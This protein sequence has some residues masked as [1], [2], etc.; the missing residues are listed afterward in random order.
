MNAI[1]IVMYNINW[2]NNA[3]ISFL[4]KSTLSITKEV[5]FMAALNIVF[6][7]EVNKF[8]EVLMLFIKLYPRFLEL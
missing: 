2:C 3:Y 8:H 1:R 5:Y 4:C 6:F 7:D